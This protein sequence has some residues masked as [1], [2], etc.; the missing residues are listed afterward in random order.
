MSIRKRLLLIIPTTTYRTV[1]FMTAAERLNIEIIV[2]S[3]QPQILSNLVP[4]T[5]I[6]IDLH[7]IDKSI[8]TVKRFY[9]KTPFQAVLG[10]DDKTVL[11]ASHINRSLFL[12]DN[13]VKAVE[14]TLNK[15]KMRRQ[16]KTGGLPSPQFN[17]YST[18]DNPLLISEKT[19]YPCVLKPIFLSGSR[20]VIRADNKIQFT[21][22]FQKITDLLLDPNVFENEL[23][24]ATKILV[25]DYI[26]GNEIAIEGIV[27]DGELK[28]LALFDKP[29][30]LEGP[31]FIETIYVTPSRLNLDLQRKI[32]QTTKKA[33]KILGL[34]YGPI[35]AELRINESGIWFIEIAAR[36]IGGY[37]SNVL[38]FND[39]MTLEELILKSALGDDIKELKRENK[40]A[41]VMMIPIP[42]TGLLKSIGNLEKAKSVIGITDIIIS[43]PLN[44]EVIAPPM[45]SLYLGFIFAN[46]SS[47]RQ[48]ERAIRNAYKILKINIE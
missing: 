41:G 10:V 8:E 33:V 40:A 27:L 16:I 21:D 14:S 43:I 19:Q 6:K 17:L 39:Q 29:D 30:P 42:K 4:D 9:R 20:G 7:Q 2:A 44:Q 13:P 1:A 32:F 36:S 26:P 12:P 45:G 15:Y 28:L 25:E 24:L 22:A 3:E 31:F 5:T 48:A 47:P 11:L 35:H 34:Q 46:A 37:C 18:T 23:Q 38:K